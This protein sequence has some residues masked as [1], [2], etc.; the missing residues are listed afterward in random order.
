MKMAERATVERKFF[1]SWIRT[2][3]NQMLVF[4]QM[5]LVESG[6]TGDGQHS[7]HF[8]RPRVVLQRHDGRSDRLVRRFERS[9]SFGHIPENVSDVGVEGNGGRRLYVDL[10]R[11]A[12]RTSSALRRLRARLSSQRLRSLP[13]IGLSVSVHC[14]LLVG[15]VNHFFRSLGT[16]SLVFLRPNVESFAR[17][18][19]IHENKLNSRN[20]SFL[21]VCASVGSVTEDDLL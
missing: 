4:E 20:L 12:R 17:V 9:F 19:T 5:V 10:L 15:H 1:T 21:T 13:P 11:S 2:L 18:L 16:Q 7:L 8:G 3:T 14:L 6:Q